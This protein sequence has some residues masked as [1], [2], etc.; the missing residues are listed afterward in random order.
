MVSTAPKT[1]L[2]KWLIVEVKKAI[3]LASHKCHNKFTQKDDKLKWARALGY[4]AQTMN[5]ILK[6]AELED[7]TQRIKILEA[8]KNGKSTNS[9]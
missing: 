6:D 2:Q 5:S 1:I 4:L 9:G 7:L 8:E 3:E